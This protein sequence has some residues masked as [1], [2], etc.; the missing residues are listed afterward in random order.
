MAPSNFA[1]LQDF[2]LGMQSRQDRGYADCRI[3]ES[4]YHGPVSSSTLVSDS[5]KDDFS[6]VV[7]KQTDLLDDQILLEGFANGGLTEVSREHF[8]SCSLATQMAYELGFLGL[9]PEVSLIFSEAEHM[10]GMPYCQQIDKDRLNTAAYRSSMTCS[11]VRRPRCRSPA[12]PTCTASQGSS[13]PWT[14]SW[15]SR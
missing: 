8:R 5:P 9:K 6:Q 13:R 2:L 14:W 12:L 7:Y 15:H 10:A 11:R 3:Y 4:Y 1:H